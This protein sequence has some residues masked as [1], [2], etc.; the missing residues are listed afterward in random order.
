VL[1]DYVADHPLPDG[2]LACHDQMGIAILRFLKNRSLKIPRQVRVTGFNAFENWKYSDPLLTTV[3]TP[4]NDL[5]RTAGE[6][7]L[8]R[9]KNG[10][11]SKKNIVL[12]VEFIRGNST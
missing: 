1:T 11:F 2:I 9:L 12:P 5:G 3:R 7:L 10:A 6:Q 4:A 8:L